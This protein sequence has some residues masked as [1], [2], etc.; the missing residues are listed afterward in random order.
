MC[1]CAPWRRVGELQER[2]WE[3]QQG[4]NEGPIHIFVSQMCF[5]WQNIHFLNNEIWVEMILDFVVKM[6]ASNLKY[7]KKVNEIK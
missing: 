3:A 1:K 7:K 4:E 6:A 5:C 2:R